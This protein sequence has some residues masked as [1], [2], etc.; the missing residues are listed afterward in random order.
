MWVDASEGRALHELVSGA[1]EFARRRSEGGE[2]PGIASYFFQLFTGLPVE[3]WNPVRKR[4]ILVYALIVMLVLVFVLEEELTPLFA[5]HSADLLLIPVAFL[6]GEHPWTLI[7]HAFLHANLVHLLGNL[8]FLWI[9]GDNVED[10]LGHRRFALLYLVCLLGGAAGHVAFN[11]SSDVPMLGA[12]GAISGLMGAYL[13]LFPRVQ[14]WVVFLFIRFR[15]NILVYLLF[16]I[17]Y[18]VIMASSGAQEVAWFAHFGGF[19]MGTISGLLL[20]PRVG[21]HVDTNAG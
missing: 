9:F 11:P 17:G 14:V 5:A 21:P 4:P 15:L 3:V 6:R 19:A 8:Y 2:S 16:W 12:S 13:A 18:Q 1:Q 7:T 20:R 10:V